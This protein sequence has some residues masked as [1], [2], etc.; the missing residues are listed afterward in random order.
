MPYQFTPE[1]GAAGNSSKGYTG[2]GLANYPNG[3]S[4]DGEYVEGVDFD[5]FSYVVGKV[6][7]PTVMVMSILANSVPI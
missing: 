2:R 4:Y 1:G 3:E 6:N 5:L 7:T